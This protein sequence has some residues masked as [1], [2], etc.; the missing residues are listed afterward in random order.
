MERGS[1]DPIA[2]VAK[3]TDEGLCDVHGRRMSYCY[4][5]TM[6]DTWL[7]E[8]IWW[9]KGI[10]Y[11]IYPRSFMDS[12]GDGVGDLKGIISK[13]DYIQ[14]LNVSCIWLSPIY[15]SPM[16]DCGYDIK[17]YT[18]ID[19]VFGDLNDFD[20]LLQGC[21][22]RGIRLIM[23][24]VPNHTSDEHPFFVRSR[25]EGPAGPMR[26]WYVWR[27]AAPDGGPP[28]NWKSFFGG[29]AWEFDEKSGQ[30]YLHQFVRGKVP[31]SIVY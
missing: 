15:P 23:D 3:T 18:N 29:S 16:K 10:I 12:N 28:N 27:D 8:C 21:H 5:N 2:C 11:Q 13:L 24:L 31:L 4:Y 17:N 26:N 25:D 22:E 30:Y 6:E 14:S 19:P 20:E 9:K 7:K 1:T